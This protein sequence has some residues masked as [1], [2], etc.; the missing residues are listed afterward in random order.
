MSKIRNIGFYFLVLGLILS[1]V[2]LRLLKLALLGFCLVLLHLRKSIAMVSD[3]LE[4]TTECTVDMFLTM[5][6]F[7]ILLID[8]A[9]GDGE[10]GTCD[11]LKRY[12]VLVADALQEA[13]RGIE[14]PEL[15]QPGEDGPSR[16]RFL[17]AFHLYFHRR[18]REIPQ[19]L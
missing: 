5:A 10:N 2:F 15:K 11:V 19:N 8:E 9:C 1:D 18:G 14:S 16:H 17:A 7:G 3:F 6:N 4:N 13:L 12:S